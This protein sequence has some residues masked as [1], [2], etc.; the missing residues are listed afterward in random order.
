MFALPSLLYGA[1]GGMKSQAKLKKFTLTIGL[2][3]TLALPGIASSEI[4]FQDNFD[5]QPE[6]M[7]VSSRNPGPIPSSWTNAR[8]DEKWHPDEGFPNNE[9]SMRITGRDPAMVRG[10]SGKAFV[11]FNE[12]SSSNFAS[13]S[14][15][16]KYLGPEGYTE[17][18]VTFW[19]KYEDDWNWQSGPFDK[20]FRIFSWDGPDV[21][22]GS[23]WD[24]FEDGNSAPIY[25]Y[26]YAHNSFGQ[27][28]VHA[29]RCD[30]QET[31]YYCKDPSFDVGSLNSLGYTGHSNNYTS[32]IRDTS[33]R[34]ND[35]VN[36]G[37]IPDTGLAT[38]PQIFG[39]VW[40]QLKFQ[41]RMNSAPGIKDGILRYWLDGQLIV[42]LTN[43][44]WMS[45]GSPGNKRWNFVAIGGNTVTDFDLV[46]PTEDR[47]QWYA[48]DDFVV[49]TTL[50]PNPP[51]EPRPP[52][53]LQI[54]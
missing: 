39:N 47:E 29:Y 38:H 52:S 41:V 27:R 8:T 48:I 2:L 28:H 34:I 3:S 12:S 49:S 45:T 46:G 14:I 32:H 35:L 44:P 6:W 22:N 7:P 15:L 1:K 33:P 42:N 37:L 53:N 31:A 9:P 21:G 40:H 16:G 25:F 26:D 17:L 5:N 18:T 30:P 11:V 54:Q 36:E 19:I 23:P 13:D 20:V 51:S 50:E 4:I 24:F 10:G 43:I